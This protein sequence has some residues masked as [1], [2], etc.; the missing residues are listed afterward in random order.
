MSDKVD[1]I[2]N[3]W[4]VTPTSFWPAIVTDRIAQLAKTGGRR[5]KGILFLWAA[6]NENCLINYTADQD[7]PYTNGWAQNA[8]GSWSWVG[9]RTATRFTN[10]LV[11]IPG[12]MH[13]AALA[14][15]A[16]RSHYSNYGP[17][18]LICAPSSNSHAYSRKR[19]PGLA[20][21]T[22]SGLSNGVTSSF[23]GTSSATPLVAG[24]AALALSANANLSALDVA[25]LLKQTASKNLDFSGYERTPPASYDQNTDW[26]VSPIAPFKQPAFNDIDS[27]DGTWSG[28][29]GYGKA[30]AQAVVAKAL[31]LLP[32]DTEDGNNHYES[33]PEKT[34]PDNSVE[35][36][37]DVIEVTNSGVLSQIKTAVDLDH[38]WIGDLQIRLISPTGKIVLLHDRTGSNNDNI[39]QT[40]DGN[41]LPALQTLRQQNIQGVWTLEV[42]DSASQDIGVLNAWSLDFETIRAPIEVI[43]AEATRIPDNNID[44]ISRSLDVPNGR[45][46]NTVDISVDITHPWIADLVITLTPPNGTPI[47]LHNRS[48]NSAD[49]IKRTW[50][51]QDIFELQTLI[52]QDSGGQWRLSV[53]DQASRDEGKLNRWSIAIH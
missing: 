3:S 27:A 29:F 32:E 4:G 11:G 46:I 15:N 8:G 35:G 2:S 10:S 21:T 9:V 51:S 42:I 17:G 30:D 16:M 52:G 28:W 40:Y 53:A 26:D 49:N 20:V 5:G 18:V 12:V 25:S 39:K 37:R 38:S 14:S 33:K 1:I 47:L 19:L 24:I 41:N 34:I 48:G 45:T 7:V 23:G 13:V 50:R 43:D 31:Q 44:G 36:L 6:G 22:T